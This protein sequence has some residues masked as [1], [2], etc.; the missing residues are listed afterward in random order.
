[1]CSKRYYKT[2]HNHH[3]KTRVGLPERNQACVRKS[4]APALIE[5]RIQDRILVEEEKTAK[6]ERYQNSAFHML[7]RE[8][9][10]LI[11]T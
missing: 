11:I 5:A 7:V 8:S 6:W 2:D 3:N 9:D 4:I 1:M 10:G